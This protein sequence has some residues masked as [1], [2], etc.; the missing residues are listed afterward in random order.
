MVFCVRIQ[1]ACLALT[2]AL[3]GLAACS[4]SDP[5][6]VA[7]RDD[8]G[9]G[10]G[11][12]GGKD[13]SADVSV[14]DSAAPDAGDGGGM[15]ASVAAVRLGIEPNPPPGGSATDQ[16]ESQLDVL[17]AGSRGIPL[18][19]RWS[20]LYPS[21]S[22]A[23]AKVWARLASTAELIR[24]A[25]QQT[26]F[27]LAVVN[28]EQDARPSGLPSDWGAPATL[29]AADALV[30]T[31]YATFDDELGYLAVGTDV[32]L[33]LAQLTSAQ[34]QGFVAFAKHV[35]SYAKSHPDKPAMLRVGVTITSNGIAKGPTPE[36][37]ELLA[38]SD[39]AIVTYTAVDESFMARPASTAAGDLDAM[40][41]ALEVEAGAALPI[42]LQEVAYPSSEE[43]GS[44]ETK[45]TTF[46]DGLA[47]ALSARRAH[48]PFVGIRSL[49]D[50]DPSTCAAEAQALGAP[51]NAAAIATSCS[52]G[53]RR[54]DGTPKPA[55]ASVYQALATFATP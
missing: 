4:S 55:Q 5:P 17:A 45:Q 39:V 37:S 21:P 20:E 24:N 49:Y 23:D 35:L 31:T 29:A 26:L 41:T 32:D 14:P 52:L 48:H 30:D 25:Q 13:G 47:Q 15:D 9:T 1:R 51:G 10:G 11:G 7:H 54:A 38:A 34:K 40:E 50:A 36:L 44:S 16:L 6:E 43:A 53:L 12:G 8:A 46:F 28:H 3:S 42:V 22:Q 2:I 27:C 18:V 33:F 19:R